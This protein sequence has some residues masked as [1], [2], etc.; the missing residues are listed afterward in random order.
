MRRTALYALGKQ[1]L[2]AAGVVERTDHGQPDGLC[3]ADHAPDDDRL[4]PAIFA[5]NH[6][7]HLDSALILTSLPEPW[8]HRQ[9][10]RRRRLRIAIERR[11]PT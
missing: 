1:V 8:R 11:P 3:L 6:H 10:A 2:E 5:A 7:S 9:P 4:Q